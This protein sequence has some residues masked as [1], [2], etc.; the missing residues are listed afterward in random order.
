MNTVKTITTRHL[1]DGSPL[2]ASPEMRKALEDHVLPISG[3]RH[4]GEVVGLGSH[5]RLFAK[6]VSTTGACLPIYN[7]WTSGD[8]GPVAHSG[9]KFPNISNKN[10]GDYPADTSAPKCCI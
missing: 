9:D 7:I 10:D 1:I 3:P 8:A 5:Y 2:L 4:P 6:H